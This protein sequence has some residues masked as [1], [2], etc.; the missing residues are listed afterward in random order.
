MHLARLSCLLV[1][2][3]AACGGSARDERGDQPA[4]SGGS[5]GSGGSSQSAFEQFCDA[6]G[7][8]V[9]EQCGEHFDVDRCKAG[10]DCGPMLLHN[11]GSPLFQCLLDDACGGGCLITHYSPPLDLSEA[12]ETFA[13]RCSDKKQEGCAL[14][15]D[16]CFA[17]ALFTDEALGVMSAC[18]DLA[19]CEDV[20]ACI[21]A[22]YM[23]CTAW[24]YPA[25]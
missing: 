1:C 5:G 21:D 23:R 16:L 20:Q 13:A 3:F 17:G 10:A 18:L 22:S 11:P 4:G 8:A 19:T 12:G 7:A 6:R 14:F 24:V 25:F 9:T 2:A 15:E